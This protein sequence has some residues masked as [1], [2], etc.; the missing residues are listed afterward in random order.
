MYAMVCTQPYLGQA[1]VSFQVHGKS[2]KA[3]LGCNQVDSMS[4]ESL[5]DKGSCLKVKI[6][7][8]GVGVR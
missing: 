5:G 2:K 4:L 1:I 3:T 8:M 7:F 6:K